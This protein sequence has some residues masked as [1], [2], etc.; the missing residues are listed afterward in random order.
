MET[1]FGKKDKHQS[2]G[3]LDQ[4][5]GTAIDITSLSRTIM[6]KGTQPSSEDR[7]DFGGFLKGL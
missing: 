7:T 3:F 5:I 1:R 6:K 4:A 2:K